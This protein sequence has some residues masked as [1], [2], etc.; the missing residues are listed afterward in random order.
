MAQIEKQKNKERIKISKLYFLIHPG[1]TT[2]PDEMDHIKD[3]FERQDFKYRYN[4]LPE[5][6]IEKAREMKPDELMMAFLHTKIEKIKQDIR[7]DKEYTRT[8]DELKKS[9]WQK[10]YCGQQ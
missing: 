4:F 6:Y 5:R 7:A 9:S 2:D 1:S 8:L 10:A 3:P